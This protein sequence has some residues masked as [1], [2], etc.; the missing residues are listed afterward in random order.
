MKN[1]LT[2]WKKRVIVFQFVY[3][4][5]ISESTKKEMLKKFN[6]EIEIINDEYIND[7][8]IFIIENIKDLEKLLSQY[9]TEKWTIDRIDCID[10]AIIYSALS[11]Y[12]V[13]NV[14]K[15]IIIDQ[16]I[17]TSK[18]YGNDNSYKFI[19]SILDKV[20]KNEKV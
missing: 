6:E 17:I 2:Q 13:H 10:K 8:C 15:K 7:I 9:L 20:I 19:N 1:N 4:I 18:K 3:S 11:E 16:A 12:K 5:L 14:D